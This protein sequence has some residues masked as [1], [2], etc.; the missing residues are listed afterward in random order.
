MP[1][2][3]ERVANAD[4]SS[5]ADPSDPAHANSDHT[6][7]DGTKPNNV[8]TVLTDPEFL[9][10][11]EK[12]PLMRKAQSFAVLLV[13][14]VGGMYGGRTLLGVE[15]LQIELPVFLGIGAAVG[16]M[17]FLIAGDVD[18]W[19]LVLGYWWFSMPVGAAAAL[20]LVLMGEQATG[21]DEVA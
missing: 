16:G 15:L 1:T 21:M 6:T 3:S 10:T 8:F 12:A 20:A 13:L 18:W 11:T 19:E 4:P 14:V 17:I 2:A 7:R 5:V 9:P